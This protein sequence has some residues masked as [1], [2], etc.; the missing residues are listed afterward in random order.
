MWLSPNGQFLAA[1]DN[2]HA[3]QLWRIADGK[4]LLREELRQCW[5]SAFSPDSR[6]LAVAKDDWVF[7]I[8][9]ASG[10]ETRRWRLPA[11]AHRLAFDPNNRRLAVGYSNST[12]ASIYDSAQGSHVAD[13]PVGL[14]EHQVVAWH[15]DGARLAVAGSDPHIQI[16]DVVAKRKLATLEGHVQH[17]RALDF[18]P[19]G[20]L[21]ASR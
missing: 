9:L 17:V 14:M 15:P 11:A 10:Q 6:R 12:V 21:L 5:T 8:D 13:L 1:H 2:Q 3:L 19:D 18:H 7:C 16:W 20:G 4:S